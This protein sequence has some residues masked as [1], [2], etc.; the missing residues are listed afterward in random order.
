MKLLTRMIS[1]VISI[2]IL[3]S[4]LSACDK[5]NDD[6]ESKSTAETQIQSVEQTESITET[7]A[8]IEK[9]N[10][11]EDLYLYIE[12]AANPTKYYWA[13]ESGNDAMSQA[14]FTRQQIVYD[15]LGV[16]IVG[17]EAPGPHDYTE[18]FKTTV[19]NKDGSIDVMLSH[20]Y[21][22]VDGFV[23]GNYLADLNTIPEI[24]IDADYW[25][26]TFMEDLSL[27]GKMFLGFS[28]FNIMY[29]HVIAFNKELMSKYSSALSESVYEMVDGYRWTLDQMITLANMVYVD[30]ESNGK[31]IDDTFGIIGLQDFPFSG[32][33]HSCD[34]NLVD[35]D[36]DGAY[37]VSVYNE[38]NKN[39]TNTLIEKLST[40]TKSDCAW[41]WP[42]KSENKVEFYN[43]KALMSISETYSLPMYLDYD[44]D[45]GILPY[46]MYDEAQKE[47]GYR[48][49]QWGGY[50]CVP[51]YT[52]NVSMVGDTIEALSYF[53]EDVNVTFYEK[54][55]GKQASDSPDDTRMLNV[56]W[57]GICCDFAQAYFNAISE[58]YLLYMVSSLTS[59]DATQ[60]TSSYVASIENSVNKKLSKLLK[61]VK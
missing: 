53:S 16:D 38:I 61:S 58:S 10:Y 26:S 27:N 23:T 49:L 4:A 29:T 3:L 14:I 8:V 46:P 51:S 42:Y 34:I 22:G 48:S 20:S 40:L 25:N 18:A 36:A 45:F 32:F 11:G 37:T 50:I 60:S 2:A 21:L 28:D 35:M 1:A 17:V 39:K 44:I 5:S 12:P 7:E 56:V 54:L 6:Y 52:R 31:T 30:T 47:V 9:K 19:M 59:E 33:L 57:D 43:G 15:T 41:F 24:S 55:L 13:K